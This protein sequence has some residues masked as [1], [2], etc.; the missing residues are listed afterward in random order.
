MNETV[1]R[2]K[3]AVTVI[4]IAPISVPTSGGAQLPAEYRAFQETLNCPRLTEDK[5]ANYRC[6]I[7][8]YT[9]YGLSSGVDLA[10]RQLAT[11]EAI[12]CHDKNEQLLID[13]AIIAT[14]KC[15]IEVYAKYG[16]ATA[17]E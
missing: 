17:K 5:K 9:K 4:L 3:T 10:K 2:V 16:V 13:K 8:I 15:Q 12:E 1:R 14:Y 7:R 11:T 6:Q